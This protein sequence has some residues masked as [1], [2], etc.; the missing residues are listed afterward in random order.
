MSSKHIS[1]VIPGNG[2]RDFVESPTYTPSCSSA[3]ASASS[4]GNHNN[5]NNNRKRRSLINIPSSL[6]P[7]RGKFHKFWPAGS[8]RSTCEGELKD[9]NGHH[10]DVSEVIR[11]AGVQMGALGNP[12]NAMSPSAGGVHQDEKR[13]RHNEFGERVVTRSDNNKV[14][15]FSRLPPYLS[16]PPPPLNR[17]PIPD[18]EPAP[19]PPPPPP[20]PMH[21][22]PPVPAPV[23]AAPPRPPPPPPPLFAELP[24][25]IGIAVASEQRDSVAASLPPRATITRS[26]GLRRAKTP[27]RKVG[28]LERAARQKR[29]SAAAGVNRMSSV[30][31]IARQYRDL[32]E[33]PE[34]PDVPEVPPINPKFLAQQPSPAPRY[35]PSEYRK[36]L[37]FTPSPVSDDGT[38]VPSDHDHGEG[39]HKF[40]R[41]PSPVSPPPEHEEDKSTESTAPAPAA[42][43]FQVG[44]DLLTRELSSALASNNGGTE[45]PRSGNRAS[46]LQVWLMI[47]AYERLRDQLA[48]SG[49][50]NE[51][52]RMAIDAWLEALHAIHRDMVDGAAY[53]DSEYEDDDVISLSG[54]A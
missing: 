36:S 7:G 32:V 51:E 18:R 16:P 13:R 22:P 23:R 26:T 14:H 46:G 27:V 52:V 38:L 1:L 47:E 2:P 30:S 50:Q 9:C 49:T 24:A 21:A 17:K 12:A 41:Y 45:E 33:Y 10:T 37:L 4:N 31:T 3:S 43:R 53:S 25:D 6:I 39:Q 8:R 19:F 11:L 42:L 34:E 40:F 5:N 35:D 28:Q 15:N 48:A 29:M 54:E 44:L 20:V